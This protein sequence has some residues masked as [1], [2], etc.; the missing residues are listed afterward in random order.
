[1]DSAN[2]V[3]MARLNKNVPKRCAL[4]DDSPLYRAMASFFPE[5]ETAQ[6]AGYSWTQINDAIYT[7]LQKQGW[8]E[9]FKYSTVQQFYAFWK[10]ERST[11]GKTDFHIRLD[12]KVQRGDREEIVTAFLKILDEQIAVSERRD[13]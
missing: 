10:K 8:T 4:C 1:M 3:L 6:K 13:E 11:G 2:G 12:R 9:K 5:I 7:E